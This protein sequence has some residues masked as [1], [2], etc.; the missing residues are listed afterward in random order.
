MGRP[1]AGGHSGGDEEVM[2]M[3][4][5]TKLAGT[6]LK[7]KDFKKKT[8]IMTHWKPKAE[9]R[10]SA[11]VAIGY[12]LNQLKEGKIKEARLQLTKAV[13]KDFDLASRRLKEVI[14]ENKNKIDNGI[15]MKEK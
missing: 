10:W 11:G 14:E 13:K 4:K 3:D 8:V 2:K 7:D 1:N 9:Y 6:P 15:K 12:Y 5:N